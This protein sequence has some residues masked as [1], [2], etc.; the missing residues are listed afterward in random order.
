VGLVGLVV[1]LVGFGT[2]FR[3]FSLT[4]RVQLTARELCRAVLTKPN[5][6]DQYSLHPLNH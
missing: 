6:P 1:G 4:A 2:Q 3:G 5:K